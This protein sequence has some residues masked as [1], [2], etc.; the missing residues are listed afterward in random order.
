MIFSRG[1]L[2]GAILGALLGGAILI[3]LMPRGVDQGD[4]TGSAETVD[5]SSVLRIPEEPELAAAE[6]AFLDA[7]TD[8]L[9]SAER[10]EVRAR[11]R[12]N[13]GTVV[14]A[15][16]RY[17][18]AAD[19]LLIATRTLPTADRPFAHFNLGN[20]DLA[21]AF[22]DS[23][24]PERETRLRRAIESY[25]A[26]LLGDPADLDAKWNLELAR[27]LLEGDPPPSAGGGG[28]GGGGGD[29]PPEPGENQ[30]SPT[31]AQGPGPE[32]SM[33]PEEAESLLRSAQDRELQVQR[34]SLR[35][36]QPPGPIRP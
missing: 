11:A 7:V 16:A 34:E 31:P 1:V 14:L 15:S 6:A 12:Y 2:I 36:P 25:K 23:L 19:H 10:P 30:P 8:S 13:L 35:K 20:T 3:A 4:P 22:A 17:E 32:P 5:S 29:G 26:A 28:G 18:D 24:L 21:P 33:S 9:G 27:R